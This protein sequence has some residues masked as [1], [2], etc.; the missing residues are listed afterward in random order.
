MMKNKSLETKRMTESKIKQSPVSLVFVRACEQSGEK[1]FREHQ[2]VP[3]FSY[4]SS[5][6]LFNT[7]GNQD[8]FLHRRDSVNIDWHLV[9]LIL[10]FFFSSDKWHERRVSIVNFFVD[11]LTW[12]TL[13]I[14]IDDHLQSSLPWSSFTIKGQIESLRASTCF[15]IDVGIS[16]WCNGIDA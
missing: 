1:I 11:E 13:F 6:C 16:I 15:D 7:V 2:Q 12:N 8:A 14:F 4:S 9:R 10:S 5:A 3:N